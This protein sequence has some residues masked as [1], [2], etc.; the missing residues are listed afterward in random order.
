ME[1]VEVQKAL[2]PLSLK[3]YIGKISW[4]TYSE[5]LIT[6]TVKQ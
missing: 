1:V 2:S 3:R 4:K 5:E 6:V